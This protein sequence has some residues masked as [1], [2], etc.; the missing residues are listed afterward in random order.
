MG[1]YIYGDITV[2]DTQNIWGWMSADGVGEL[3]NLQG[4]TQ[5]TIYRFWKRVGSTVEH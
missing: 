3:E 2:R 4:Q 5:H 1:G